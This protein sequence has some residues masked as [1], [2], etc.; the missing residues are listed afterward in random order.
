MNS[1]TSIQRGECAYLSPNT[2]VKKKK[3]FLIAFGI[4]SNDLLRRVLRCQGFFISN[5]SPNKIFVKIG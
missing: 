5:I 2:V 4:Y 3:V 1:Q